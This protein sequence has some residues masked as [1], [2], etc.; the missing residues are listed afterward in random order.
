[1]AQENPSCGEGQIADELSLKLSLLVDS[2]TVGKYLKQGGRPR[3]PSEPLT[4]VLTT[5]SSRKDMR[6]NAPCESGSIKMNNLRSHA[7]P[8]AAHLPVRNQLVARSILLGLPF[9]V[10][11]S[12]FARSACICHQLQ[13]NS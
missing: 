12:S 10:C 6:G 1:M 8:F 2:R 11:G 3:Q 4:T 13:H 7:Y 5:I 9:F